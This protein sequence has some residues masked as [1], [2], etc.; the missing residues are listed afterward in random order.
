MG[1]YITMFDQGLT[2]FLVYVHGP[3]HIFYPPATHD[4]DPLFS[5]TSCLG[6]VP[7][8]LRNPYH[9]VPDPMLEYYTVQQLKGY[10]S[11]ENELSFGSNYSHV[12]FCTTTGQATDG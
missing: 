6:Q 7:R 8:R 3:P 9:G 12:V 5:N 4:K 10:A 11:M 2:S 1:S